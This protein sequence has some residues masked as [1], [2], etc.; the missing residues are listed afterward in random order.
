[1][2]SFPWYKALFFAWSAILV[3]APPPLHAQR[4]YLGAVAGRTSAELPEDVDHAGAMAGMFFQV[5]LWD[6]VGFRSEASWLRTG[7]VEYSPVSS[8][9]PPG[10]PATRNLDYLEVNAVGRLSLQTGS[11]PPLGSSIGV[12]VFGGGWLGTRVDGSIGGSKPR[13][14]DLGHLVGIGLFWGYDRLLLQVDMRSRHG[15]VRYWDHGPRNRGSLLA[16][17]L[18]YRVH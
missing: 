17:S 3:T 9:P 2:S 6:H 4:A 13:G 18:G 16:F 7:A 11:L 5:D 12:S 8:G 1:M 14:H 10:T 15:E